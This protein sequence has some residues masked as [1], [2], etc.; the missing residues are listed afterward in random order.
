MPTES[1]RERVKGWRQPGNATFVALT[2]ADPT[3][4]APIWRAWAL[5][6]KTVTPI[7]VELVPE[8]ADIYFGMVGAWP[9]DALAIELVSII[10]LGSI[11]AA[12]A[13]GLSEYGIRRLALVDYDRLQFHNLARHRLTA[14]DVGRFKVNAMRDFLLQRDPDSEVH[15]LTLDV[16]AHANT[17]RSLFR[18]SSI[19]VVCSDGVASRRAAN[20]LA[21]WAATP[22]IL[23][24]VLEDGGIGEVLRV[25]PG[26]TSCL[27][28]FRERLVKDGSVD[29]EPGLDRGYGT[30]SRHLPMTAV[31]GDLD[32][33]GKLAAKAAVATLLERR[34]YLEQWLPHDHLVIGLRPPPSLPPPFNVKRAGDVKWTDTGKPLKGC[35][36]CRAV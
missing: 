3:S 24:C 33:V 31:G 36:S 27:A 6:K 29:P 11:G 10:G 15:A 19:V 35:P 18:Q 7:T 25:K 34:G 26:V 2:Y 22:L 21:C 32:L 12:V 17:I 28:C 8:T 1:F 13:E 14:R 23:A 30:G 9:L 4:G 5:S 20:H 16:I